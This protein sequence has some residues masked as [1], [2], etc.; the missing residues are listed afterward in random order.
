ML[1]TN[2]FNCYSVFLVIVIWTL[3][4]H[5]GC[6][7]KSAN[8]KFSPIA[9]SSSNIKFN[10]SI[11]EKLMPKNALNEF[12]YMGGGVGILDVDND[13]KKDI[14]FCG[15]QVS[16]ALYLN[17]G[18]N[19]FEDITQKAGIAT[20]SWCSGVSVVDINNDGY[21]DLYVCV[22]NNST[23]SHNSNLLFIN[24]HN[25]TFKEQAKEYGLS[26]SG[27][28]SQAVFFDYDLDGDLD[29]YLANYFLNASYSANFLF[30]KNNSGNSPA[31]D[32][33]FR[34]D[35]DSA[36]TG[37]PVF[38]DVSMAAG[39]KENG[40]GLSVV[41][42]D[43]N[44]DGWPD[45]YVTNDFVY[46][47]ELWLNN[48]NG[49][50][51]N[52]IDSSIGHQSYSSMGCD[53]ADFNNDAK[54]DI[55]TLDMMPEDNA[56]KKITFSFMNYTR[57]QQERQMGYAP[58]FAR[59]MLQLNNGNEIIGQ[60]AVPYFSE[61]GQLA[62]ISETD[63]SWSVLMA[64]FDNDGYKDMHITNGIG[65][66]FINADFI[67]F[68]KTTGSNINDPEQV[69]KL[70]NDKL[71]SLQH[72]ELPNY[73]FLNNH[74][75]SFKN[76]SDSSGVNEKSI[77][78]GAAYADLDN[79]GDLDLVV[80]NINKNA[81]V[82]INNTIQKDKSIASHSIGFI[83]QGNNK[84]KKAYGAKMYLHVA[85][86]TQVQEESPVRGYLSS[87]DSKL[88][89]GTGNKNK[90]D[91]AVVIWPDNTMSALYDLAADSIYTL[92]QQ[93]AKQPWQPSINTNYLFTDVTASVGAV[94][95]H[96][97]VSF[98]DYDVQRLLP[99]KF[100]QQGPFISTG[101][102]NKDGNID[103]FIGGGF[104]SPGALFTQQADGKFIGKNFTDS[105]KF[106]EDIANVFFDADGDGDQDLL[107]TYGDVRYTDTS[108]FYNPHLYLNDG[109]GHFTFAPNAIPSS[110]KTIAGCVTVADYDGDGDIDIF[111][112]GRVSLKYPLPAASFILQNDKGIFKDVTAY[113]CPALVKPGMIT[114]AAWVDFDNDKQVDLVIAGEF[115]PISFFKN[116]QGKLSDVTAATG[117]IDRKGMWRSI[118]V[119]DIDNDGDQDFICGN[120]G[121]NNH[122]AI[123]DAY[124]MKLF[125][126]DMD[127]NGSIDPLM[128][129][130]Q[131]DIDGKRKLFPSI[132]RD[133]FASQVPMIKKS[134][135]L[136]ADYAKADFNSIYKDTS[137]MHSFT[138]NEIRSCWMENLGSGKFTVHALPVEAQFA[139]VN[140]IICGDV[141]GDG[142]N[143]LILAGNEYQT[144]VMTGRYDASYSCFLKGKADKTF[145]YVPYEQT[146]LVLRGDVRD[147]KLIL[148]SKKEK[149]LLV[150]VNNGP[151]KIYQLHTT[152]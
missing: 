127:G 145:N 7:N 40:Y 93:D 87:V 53:V 8:Y 152:K 109:K 123:S 125:A 29:M 144:E 10:N 65:R 71:I 14:F 77:S 108:R 74:D 20:N 68:T 94:Y 39:I 49:S 143:D 84:N 48:K 54:P 70:L 17:K 120:L 11:D 92:K 90:I 73:L 107:I 140:A 132:S 134:F 55:A 118:C 9:P 28:S 150:A 79:D 12:A 60:N 22:Y 122:Y 97:D 76:I 119:A 138:C 19:N 116:N 113:V 121:L 110:V 124:P 129:Y 117:L 13:G 6:H 5:T 80:N 147:M 104:N 69:R 151:L 30:P 137:N 57:Y 42:S 135:L 4:V 61:I 146:G 136:N 2:R 3:F 133:L 46:N 67:E 114:A 59:N 32:K 149:I 75:Y 43:V 64:D 21:D 102:I 128:F 62:G 126:K 44:N 37:H 24:Q 99:Q 15:N 27:A 83:L 58:S 72:I 131:K 26:F 36:N 91:S 34:N 41:A 1:L 38:T 33:L 86:Q 47:D 142:I 66:D 82:F 56:R 89:F 148:N 112:G 111:I 85:G 81:F 23:S 78:N 101:D 52:I 130:F 103:F 96:N 50:F 141:T 31:N 105:I 63:W 115:M 16:S 45:L 35:G 106:E 98:D 139:P 88:L 95:K 100:S 25:N 51:T 18:N